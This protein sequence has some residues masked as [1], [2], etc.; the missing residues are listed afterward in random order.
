MIKFF[1]FWHGT[2]QQDIKKLCGV[3]AAL[4]TKFCPE[5]AQQLVLE[6][7]SPT[8]YVFKMEAK[9]LAVDPLNIH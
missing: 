2:F 3:I 6:L 5:K 9:G 1:F 8:L 7:G 4:R